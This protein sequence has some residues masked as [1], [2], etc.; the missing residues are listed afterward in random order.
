MPL[1]VNADPWKPMEVA[2]DIDV[3]KICA[4]RERD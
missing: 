2:N 3:S 4:K 1:A